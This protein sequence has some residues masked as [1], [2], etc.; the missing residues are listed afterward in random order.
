MIEITFDFLRKEGYAGVTDFCRYLLTTPGK[1]ENTH[2]HVYRG[3]MLCLIVKDIKK[4]ATIEADGYKWRKYRKKGQ[5]R[6][7]EGV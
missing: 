7:G 4:A 5:Q 1:F 3:D 6:L 2:I